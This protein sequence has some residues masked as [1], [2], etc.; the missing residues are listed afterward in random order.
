[1]AHQGQLTFDDRLLLEELYAQGMPMH[2]MAQK[3]GYSRQS[4]FKELKKGYTGTLNAGGKPGY[5]AARAQRLIDIGFLN[6]RRSRTDRKKR[7]HIR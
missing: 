1:M 5:S 2:Y 7:D 4:I 6:K 3:L